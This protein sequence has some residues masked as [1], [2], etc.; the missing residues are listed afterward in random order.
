MTSSRTNVGRWC[1]F[2]SVE[3][4]PN[5]R[6]V[7]T[8]D[9]TTTL[10]RCA[11]AILVLL[12]ENCGK[13]ISKDE[14]IA[15]GWQGRIVHENSL[16]KAIG[17]VRAALGHERHRLE[18]AFGQGYQLVGE[19]DWHDGEN[20]QPAKMDRAGGP[21]LPAF[22]RTALRGLSPLHGS[23]ALAG[24]IALVVATLFLGAG[25]MAAKH[26]AGPNAEA[27]A[28][29]AYLSD[30]LIASTDPYSKEE[31]DPAL[32]K[33]VDKIA[34]SIDTRFADHP[35]SLVSLHR[36]IAKAVSGWGDYDRAVRHLDA[37]HEIAADHFSADDPQLVQ[38]DTE[39][40][41]QLRLAGNTKRGERVCERADMGARRHAPE[42]LTKAQIY[43]AKLL[44][45]IGE[46][47][48]ARQLLS[49][50]IARPGKVE[51]HLLADA[52]W[53][54][55][56]TDRKLARFDEADSAFLRHI[57]LRLEQLGRDH[58]LTGWA[59]ADYGDFLVASGRYDEALPI[60][61]I[62]QAIFEGR[63]GR[64][65]IETQS[66][67]YSLALLH[68]AQGDSAK[69]E[70]LLE[71]MLGV[72][73]DQLGVKHFWTIYTMT[74][75]A[76]IKARRGDIDAAASLLIEAQSSAEPLLYG[77][78][79]K[80]GWFRLR[81]AETLLEM[82]RSATAQTEL[83]RSQ[84]SLVQSLGRSHPWYARS[85]CTEA[86]IASANGNHEAAEQRARS[87]MRVLNSADLPD[88]HPALVMAE[89]L[90]QN[91]QLERPAEVSGGI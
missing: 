62:A 72:F 2:H 40:C 52:Y 10:D 69:A 68:A 58:P 36:M 87:C 66:P 75:L 16:A 73:R 20:H 70:A 81:W 53:F 48:S 4:H 27:E 23:Y 46:Y 14:L 50:A 38:I 59:Y 44:F 29:I 82:G 77:R 32:R 9:S 17:R 33:V 15:A 30:N 85:L 61:R 91:L 6:L 43:R 42:I 60:L 13:V 57:E 76:E 19:A 25:G 67:I 89:R 11:N 34:M 49:K 3:F 37:A 78:P 90:L 51:P 83:Q 55:G 22:F 26:P 79:G 1:I 47:K 24:F 18:T 5:Q 74:E 88:Q 12:L 39:L 8:G 84:A 35:S 71:E 64:D 28:L 41:Q 21:F 65:H 63:L 31:T 54:L 80:D 7:V 45:E 86:R 56:L